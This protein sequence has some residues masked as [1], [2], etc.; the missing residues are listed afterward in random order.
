MSKINQSQRHDI[1]GNNR[2]SE[3]SRII[4]T[5]RNHCSVKRSHHSHESG[6]RRTNERFKMKSLC[7]TP[8]CE[9]GDTRPKCSWRTRFPIR[10][11]I[12]ID[13]KKCRNRLEKVVIMDASNS[14]V[15]LIVI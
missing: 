9:M 13:I 8:K 4:F 11:S 14:C 12:F 7:Q 5:I 1:A 15:L 3:S 6:E 2:E 10:E